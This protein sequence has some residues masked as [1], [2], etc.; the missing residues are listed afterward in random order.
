MSRQA[1]K[2]YGK[3]IEYFKGLDSAAVAFSGGVDS[4]VLAKAAHDALGKKAVAMTV[5]TPANDPYEIVCA[6][7]VAKEIG[8]KHIIVR[9][10][11]LKDKK[12][13]SNTPTRC[14][15]CKR[16]ILSTIKKTAKKYKTG[17][18]IDGT[19]ADDLRENR[20]GYKAVRETKASTPLADLGLSKEKV[21]KIAET[22]NL[23]NAQKPSTPCLATRIPCGTKI[24][25]KLLKQISN[26]ESIIRS[27][28]IKQ[29]RVRHLGDS[30]A[31]E[32]FSEDQ[33]IIIEHSTEIVRRFKKLG[34]RKAFLDLT[35]R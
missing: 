35:G 29:Y 13:Y 8:I 11:Q 16:K 33:Q 25:G 31:I 20:P 4:S 28:G 30:A 10:N 21:R 1:K 34:F 24:T 18:I 6:K 5:V 14:Y 22:M 3:L 12:F 23:S 32:V 17:N 19:N 26:A 2:D 15:Y 27:L 7:K 9:L